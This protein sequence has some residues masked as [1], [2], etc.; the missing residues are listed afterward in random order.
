MIIFVGIPSLI[1]AMFETLALVS[2]LNS[3]LL[4][5][6]ALGIALI[7]A[8]LFVVYY[9]NKSIRLLKGGTGWKLLTI[10]VS[11]YVPRVILS[12][13]MVPTAIL[14]EVEAVRI[15]LSGAIIL[16]ITL[17]MWKLSTDL[18]KV[19][20]S[21]LSLAYGRYLA[22]G[23]ILFLVY[24]A[25]RT[26]S[27]FF[28]Q[29]TNR[30]IAHLL[31]VT[32][33]IDIANRA[34]ERCAGMHDILKG[35]EITEEGLNTDLMFKKAE[36]MNKISPEESTN[37]TS[38]IFST[39]MAD[40]YPL[41]RSDL[42]VERT[43]EKF[44]ALFNELFE[45]HCGVISKYN[46][47][48]VLPE[49]IEI[50]AWCKLFKRGQSYLIKEEKPDISFKLFGKLIEYGF[51]VTLRFVEAMVDIVTISNCRLIMPFDAQ[52]VSETALHRLE[53][54]LTVIGA[55]EVKIM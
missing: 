50:P 44:S 22:E 24:L 14:S 27:Y 2:N 4:V 35:N 55:E 1:I 18:K 46:V 45:H 21:F 17:G 13:F 31:P 25:W 6:N 16:F 36:N 33:G 20:I 40:F 52:T 26:S 34:L 28:T 12:C 32:G 47:L 42:G 39:V 30:I 9:L 11:L 19:N 29:L 10:G 41:I 7:F 15:S 38:S 5:L 8:L 23:V 53:R 51:E 3:A 37:F 48:E 43:K 54:E 49:D